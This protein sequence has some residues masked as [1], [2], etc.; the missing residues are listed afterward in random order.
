MSWDCDNNI[1]RMKKP[2]NQT[3][4]HHPNQTK[5]NMNFEAGEDQS[6]S[7]A[8]LVQTDMEKDCKNFEKRSESKSLKFLSGRAA[9]GA[10][11]CRP[12]FVSNPTEVKLG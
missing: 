11:L 5:P 2:T 8:N 9:A 1:L 10:K 4:P 6:S 12:I 7:T 3:K